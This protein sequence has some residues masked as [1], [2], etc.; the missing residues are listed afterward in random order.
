EHSLEVQLP[1]LQVKLSEFAIV[2]VLTGKIIPEEAADLIYPVIDDNTVV[3][4]SS[5]FSHYLPQDQAR[6]TDQKTIA[7]IL[8]GNSKGFLDACGESPIRIVM[9]LAKKMRLSPALLDARTSFETCPKYGSDDKVVGYAA[10][11]YGG[12]AD[13]NTGAANQD[14]AIRHTPS[15]SFSKEEEQFLLRLARQSLEAAVKGEKPQRPRQVPAIAKEDRGC[16]VTL[17]INGSL[18]GCIGYIE[19]IKPLFQAV[20]DNA[21]NAALNDPR[22]SRVTTNDLPQIIVEIS[23]LTKPEPLAYADP[24]DLLSKL[25]PWVDGVI[26]QKGL[27]HSTYLPQVWDHFHGDKLQFLENLARKAGMP[28]D[29]WKTADVKRY[30][31]HHFSE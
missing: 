13:Q 8:A 19:P 10:I 4:A 31:A 2:P 16:F 18:R 27:R 22:F 11:V 30:R 17:T 14:V 9:V 12:K 25:V 15:G 3:I 24:D 23:V 1:F 26:L 20:I 29:G 5:D 21:Q 7:T 6:V 28:P